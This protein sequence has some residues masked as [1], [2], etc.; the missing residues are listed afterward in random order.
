M[1]S[2]YNFL[3]YYDI[4]YEQYVLLN[5]L[6]SVDIDAALIIDVIG[7]SMNYSF[8]NTFQSAVNYGMHSI[9]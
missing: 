6:S 8:Q 3:Y 9:H 7:S 4:T 2:Q 5:C 1:T